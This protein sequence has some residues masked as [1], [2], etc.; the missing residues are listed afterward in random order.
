[1]IRTLLQMIGGDLLA[2]VLGVPLLTV[3]CESLWLFSPLLQWECAVENYREAMLAW[4]EHEEH[5][6]DCDKLQVY[7]TSALYSSAYLKPGS[8]HLLCI[9]LHT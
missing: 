4:Q 2:R 9:P 7:S 3:C 6:I 5:N 8:V 1:M